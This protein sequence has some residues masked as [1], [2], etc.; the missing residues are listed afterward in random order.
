VRWRRGSGL[1][2]VGKELGHG[3]T[4]YMLGKRRLEILGRKNQI[5]PLDLLWG[6]G[7]SSIGVQSLWEG[8]VPALPHPAPTPSV[9][10]FPSSAAD[11]LNIPS[12][13]PPLSPRLPSSPRS[14]L[15]PVEIASTDLGFWKSP[16]RQ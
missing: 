13:S 12:L 10:L 3:F 6:K 4:E 15:L 2:K 5:V 14:L 9:A 8:R 11:P 16:L 1:I 7:W